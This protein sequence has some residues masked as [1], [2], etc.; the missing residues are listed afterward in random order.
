MVVQNMRF[1]R[2]IDLR[3]RMTGRNH[4]DEVSHRR[5]LI[6]RS[7]CAGRSSPLAAF[8]Y[9]RRQE[10]ALAVSSTPW[11]LGPLETAHQRSSRWHLWKRRPVTDAEASA[12]LLARA[13]VLVA[14]DRL[15]RRQVLSHLQVM[16][17]R[18]QGLVRPIPQFRI[19]AAL[20]VA[21]EQRHGILVAAQLIAVIA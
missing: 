18:R 19:V 11:N 1:N 8:R 16:P 15:V 7:G 14:S 10:R 12:I 9:R 4:R 21:F 13:A 3:Q 5:W 20:G 17:Q 6:T 2:S